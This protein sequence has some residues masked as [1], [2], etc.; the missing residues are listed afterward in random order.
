[1]M[2]DPKHTVKAAVL[3][4]YNNEPNEGMRCIRDILHRANGRVC[5][6]PLV[7]DVFDVRH[8]GEIPDLSYD[9]YISSGGPGSPFEGEGQAWDR[10]YFDWLDKL[11]RHNE[12]EYSGKKFLFA[13]CHSFELMTRFFEFAEITPRKSK[14]FGIMPV[15]K[16]PAGKHEI[17]F[18]DLNNPFFAADIREYQVVQPKKSRIHELGAEIIALEKIRPHIDLERAVM[19]VRMSPEIVGVQ[20]HPEADPEAMAYHFQ[21]PKNKSAIIH[22]HGEEKYNIIMHR[23]ADPNYLTPTQETV[24]PNFLTNA[25]ENLRPELVFDMAI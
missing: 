25:I 20:F 14:S 7:F 5:D 6:V 22:E 23:L 15:H 11:W 19:G 21:N 9:I 10:D 17:I 3:D 18:S 16:T 8:K 24:I 12:T 1:M 4:L 13:I 2:T